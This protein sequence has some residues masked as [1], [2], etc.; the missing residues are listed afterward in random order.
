MGLFGKDVEIIVRSKEADHPAGQVPRGLLPESRK[1][2]TRCLPMGGS[3][4]AWSARWAV[5]T[6]LRRALARPQRPGEAPLYTETW[7]RR[8]PASASAHR[9]APISAQV[10]GSGTGAA[11]N[12]SMLVRFET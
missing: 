1:A 3:G 7:R 8:R 9:P 6:T 12:T 2:T 4:M 11:V 5:L 10:S